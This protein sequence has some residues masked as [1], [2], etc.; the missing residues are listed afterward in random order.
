MQKCGLSIV[1]W[2]PFQW[3]IE[4]EMDF[5]LGLYENPFKVLTTAITDIKEKIKNCD[6]LQKLFSFFGLYFL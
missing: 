2:W 3:L 6:A 5:S 1:W 4:L